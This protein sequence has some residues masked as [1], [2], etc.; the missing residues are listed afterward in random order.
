M[1][2]IPAYAGSTTADK[3][4]ALGVEDHPRVCGEHIKDMS[5]PTVAE[6]S[7][8]RMRG[9]RYLK[10][11]AASAG[12]IIPAYAGSTVWSWTKPRKSRDHPR[13]CGEHRDSPRAPEFQGG[14]SPRMRGAPLTAEALTLLQGIIPAYAGSTEH[15]SVHG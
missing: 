13:V 6:G 2:I 5:K 15:R 7:S 3:V 11:G 9:A 12:R 1:R 14:S 4:R 10:L 8:P